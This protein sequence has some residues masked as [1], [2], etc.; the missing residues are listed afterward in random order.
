MKSAAHWTVILVVRSR[1]RAEMIL[2]Q[3]RSEGFMA[4]VRPVS[5]AMSGDNDD[6]E[7]SCPASEAGEAQQILI[8]RGL[9]M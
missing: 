7:L 1:N 6:F 3:L 5:R 8:E 4:R 9:L 2:A